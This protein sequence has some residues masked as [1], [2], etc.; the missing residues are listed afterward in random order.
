[1]VNALVEATP[2][3]GPAFVKKTKSDSL[4]R[5]LEGTLQIP[6]RDKYPRSSANLKQASVSAVSPD[7]EMVTNSVFGATT[8]FLYLNSL[9][10]STLQ[11]SPARPSSQYLA[12]VPA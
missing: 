2:I 8:L 10:T 3:S 9:A 12:T 11:G 1:V 7:C 6:K 5:E 4:A